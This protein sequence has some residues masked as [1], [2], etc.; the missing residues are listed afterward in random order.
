M[1]YT[2]TAQDEFKQLF[3]FKKT[4]RKWHVALLATLCVG[5]PI[6]AGYFLNNIQNGVFACLSGLVILY[7][8][9]AGSLS[10]RMMTILI[11]S[12]GFMVSF[13]FGLIFSFNPYVAFVAFGVYSAVIHWIIRYYR[14]PPP[15]NF[16]FIMIT[17]MAICQ[18]YS[19]ETIPF[20]TGLIGL[21]TMLSCILAFIYVLWQIRRNHQ[22][23]DQKTFVLSNPNSDADLV[24]AL[25]LGVFMAL[26]L[27]IGQ[28]MGFRNPYWIPI[29]CL[30]VMQGASLY[31]VWQRS[32]QRILG[33]FIG[34]GLCWLILVFNHTELSFCISIVLLQFIVE[35]LI[36][37]NYT[38]AVLFIT[39]LTI[40]L[41]DVA[42]PLI[43]DPDTF[44]TLRFY[45]I[46]IGS[47][48]GAIGGWFIHKEKI[49]FWT[50][51]E[52]RRI[53]VGMKRKVK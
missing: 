30:A 1:N 32:V 35:L 13:V 12:F 44:I 20:K 26:A 45:E 7:L 33:T 29:S 23:K 47:V 27:A 43:Q 8:P 25:I 10:N 51:Q 4:E 41:A 39:P 14:L 21:G 19:I 3:S 11:C 46:A 18:P 40:L 6:F 42:N 5:I 24:E 50:I 37:R 49:R 34:L 38:L 15:G 36:V 48:L 2:S 9:S 16:F 52:V 53:R 28:I 31:H 22:Q 17:A